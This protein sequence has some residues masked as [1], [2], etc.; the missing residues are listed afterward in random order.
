MK[1]LRLLSSMLMLLLFGQL[2]MAQPQLVKDIPDDAQEFFSVNGVLYFFSGD[3]LWKSEGT[4]G[5][6]VLVKE[7]DE[8]VYYPYHNK[9][10]V[11]VGNYFFFTTVSDMGNRSIWRSDGT[12]INTTKAVTGPALTLLGT[13]QDK[14]IFLKN[15]E[16]WQL[17]LL[18]QEI[19]IQTLDDYIDLF[20]AT[21]DYMYLSARDYVNTHDGRFALWVSDGTENGTYSI[22]RDHYSYAKSFQPFD[23]EMYMAQVQDI[24]EM[25]DNFSLATPEGITHIWTSSDRGFSMDFTT[26]ELIAP[27]GDKLILFVRPMFDSAY[28]LW[29]YDPATNKVASI[30]SMLDFAWSS[31]QGFLEPV[32]INNTMSFNTGKKIYRSNSTNAGTYP[33]ADMY[34]GYNAEFTKVGDLLFYINHASASPASYNEEFELYQSGLF[35]QNTSSVRKLFGNTGNYGHSANLTEAGGKLF[36][37]LESNTGDKTL[38]IYDPAK[39]ADGSPY[40]TVVNADTDQDIQWLKNGDTI[41]KP[42]GLNIA[43]RFNPTGSPGSVQFWNGPHLARTENSAPF[44]FPGDNNGN[45]QPWTNANPGN[46]TFT[47]IPYS[48]PG[49]NGVAGPS[50]VVSFTIVTP[51]S[52]VPPV[53]SAGP[54]RE[55]TFPTDST[56]LYGSAIDPDG[57]ITQRQWNYVTG[58]WNNDHYLQNPNQD[59]TKVEFYYGSPGIYK[60]AYTAIDNEGLYGTDTVTV[61]V[62]DFPAKVVRFIL[63]DTD[64]DTDLQN[65]S[66]NR[67]IDL[68]TLPSNLSI[69]AETV[70]DT[71]QKVVFDYENGRMIRTEN[72]PPYALFGNAG[73]SYIP[74]LFTE[75]YHDLRAFP[76]LNDTAYRESFIRL[77]VT[78]STPGA[79]SK[80][81]LVRADTDQDLFD[82]TAYTT[83]YL[84]ELP[85][86]LNV[87]VET[88]TSAIGSVTFSLN[89]TNRTENVAPYSV[90]GDNG[91]NFN[92][93][94]FPIGDN[95][96]EAKA[97]SGSNGTG[98]YL[99]GIY[100]P[101][102]VRASRNARLAADYYEAGAQVAIVPNPSA[103]RFA[104]RIEAAVNEHTSVE[105]FNASGLSISKLYDGPGQNM[106]LQW[107]AAQ[108]PAG[109]YFCHVRS[110]NAVKT[111]KLMVVR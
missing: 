1:N 61:I 36:F 58:P 24:G 7:L 34:H 35:S 77:H 109:V 110:N 103:D 71:I 10:V 45:Y 2:L 46:Y 26:I 41:V 37:T 80:F 64:T 96:I 29:E 54:N 100:V 101:F 72:T 11:I 17:D 4:N 65:L 31:W 107:D 28:E 40:F 59:T 104:I 15:G 8:E 53:V 19:Y 13:F 95:Y 108:V 62:N 94:T 27:L 86:Q 79:L 20:S 52:K 50:T 111:Y 63:V 76:Y 88:N 18:Q 14:V 67:T 3:E 33:I 91:G 98:S 49:G 84:D 23:N 74:G 105:V 83:L 21:D 48:L 44:S 69:R 56:F 106:E 78:R 97:Y 55:I 25:A 16:L 32:V 66:N 75:G 22:L 81:V 73:A 89:N 12:T 70:P 60:F 9:T 42:A 92:G 47:A 93:G 51:A 82:L 68:S 39:P 30:R 6:T 5:T 99:N 85:A 43:L 57:Y 38:W 102:R 87:R 90:F